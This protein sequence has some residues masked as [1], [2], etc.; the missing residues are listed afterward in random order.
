MA[1]TRGNVINMLVVLTGQK[2]EAFHGLSSY[3]VGI[4]LVLGAI[5][6][7]QFLS[8][9]PSTR[10]SGMGIC[11]WPLVDLAQGCHYETDN[12]WDNL[13]QQ[14]TTQPKMSTVP[15]LRTV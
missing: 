6:P 8:Q 4:L 9:T 12:A 15:R 13:P 10:A 2:S 1:V 14:R 7:S 3:S 5:F 11:Y